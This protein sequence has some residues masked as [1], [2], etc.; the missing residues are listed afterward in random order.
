MIDAAAA[1]AERPEGITP[2]AGRF[3]VRR[4]RAEG[5]KPWGVGGGKERKIPGWGRGARW[6]WSAP[7]RPLARATWLV[8]PV[9]PPPPHRPLLPPAPGPSRLRPLPVPVDLLLPPF[10][11]SLAL[12]PILPP[13][14]FLYAV[15]LS[16]RLVVWSDGA[17]RRLRAISLGGDELRPLP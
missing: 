3:G 7:A 14:L 16:R 15:I 1:A 13:L 5:S 9:P 4:R 2:V 17:W 8:V 6:D 10:P 11:S 12:S